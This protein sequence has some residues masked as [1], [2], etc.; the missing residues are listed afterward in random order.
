WRARS[1]SRSWS[2][3]A[4][5]RARRGSSSGG[6]IASSCSRASPSARRR[7]AGREARRGD[8][9]PSDGSR[10]GAL[11]GRRRAADG[12]ARVP[13]RVGGA[14]TKWLS[15]ERPGLALA[16]FERFPAAARQAGEA[17]LNGLREGNPEREDASGLLPPFEPEALLADLRPPAAL[18]EWGER[19]RAE[20]G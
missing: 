12:P 5:G 18:D 7:G 3:G 1:A 2:T 6:T 13:R 17:V 11:A 4:C 10:P 14:A 16:W 9:G 8:R 20:P 19:A 15:Q